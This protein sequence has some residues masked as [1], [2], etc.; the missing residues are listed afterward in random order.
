[1]KNKNIS[2]LKEIAVA[3]YEQHPDR[4]TIA[5]FAACYELGKYRG[6]GHCLDEQGKLA[7]YDFS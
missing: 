6:V 3:E 5:Y 7:F 2:E 1:M 4:Y